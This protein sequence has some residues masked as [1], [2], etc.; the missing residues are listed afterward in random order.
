MSQ[1]VASHLKTD[2]AQAAQSSRCRDCWPAVALET[3][4]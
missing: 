4:A 2:R 1:I 3:P